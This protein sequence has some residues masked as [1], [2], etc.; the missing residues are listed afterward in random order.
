MESVTGFCLKNSLNLSSLA[1]K[2]FIILNNE[3]DENIYTYNVGDMQ[4]SLRQSI[5]GVD[6]EVSTNG[7]NH[8]FLITFSVLYHKK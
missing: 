6:V 5:K 3:S 4:F 8:L 7:I 2:Y 1:N